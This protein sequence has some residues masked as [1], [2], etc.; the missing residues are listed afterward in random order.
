MGM[1]IIGPNL[2]DLKVPNYTFLPNFRLKVIFFLLWVIYWNLLVSVPKVIPFNSF[3][4][5]SPKKPFLM[6]VFMCDVVPYR[7][8]S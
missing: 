5:S 1:C 2:R 3:H 7:Y 4:C 6:S 8:F